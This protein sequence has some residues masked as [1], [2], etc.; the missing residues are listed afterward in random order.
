M[1]ILGLFGR[2]RDQTHETIPLT[3]QTAPSYDVLLYLWNTHCI[4]TAR[5]E[6]QIVLTADRSPT[7]LWGRG[8]PVGGD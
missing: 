3:S 1:G 8:E 4:Q 2:A 5:S 6:G 7:V